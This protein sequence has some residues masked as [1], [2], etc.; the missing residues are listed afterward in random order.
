MALTEIEFE[1]SAA[2]YQLMG[3][4]GLSQGETLTIELESGVAAGARR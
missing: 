2:Q 3:Y 1:L 4:P